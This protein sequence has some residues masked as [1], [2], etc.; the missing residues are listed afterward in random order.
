MVHFVMEWMCG[1]IALGGFTVALGMGSKRSQQGYQN[2]DFVIW[3]YDL[4][5]QTDLSDSASI[6]HG[7]YISTIL[8]AK[9]LLP[10]ILPLKLQS[11]SK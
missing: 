6:V 8:I 5:I 2:R 9:I 10:A 7:I 11:D 1:S 4:M 3:F